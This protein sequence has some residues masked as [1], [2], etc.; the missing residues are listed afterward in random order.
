MLLPKQSRLRAKVRTGNSHEC[1]Q[2]AKK[3]GEHG[4]YRAVVDLLTATQSEDRYVAVNTA[5]A[6]RAICR[7]EKGPKA[8]QRILPELTLALAKCN[9]YVSDSLR[10]TLDEIDSNWAQAD[11][12][13]EAVPAL[14]EMLGSDEPGSRARAAEL[15]GLLRDTRSGA[16]LVAALRNTNPY[17]RATVAA[18]LGELGD[19][20]AGAALVAALKDGDTGMRSAGA[21]ALGK[22]GDPRAGA[23]LVAALKDRNAGV[24]SAAASALGELGDPRATAPLVAALE[25]K[26]ASVRGAAA[27]ALGRLGDLRAIEALV[28]RLAD[29]GCGDAA[30]AALQQMDSNWAQSRDARR[31][32][33]VLAAALVDTYSSVRDRALDALQQIDP[34]WARSDAAREALP[35]IISA[36]GDA[37]SGEA[38]TEALAMLGDRRA[39]GPLVLALSDYVAKEAALKALKRIDSHWETSDEAKSTIPDLVGL[40]GRPSA[41]TRALEVLD[42]L[43]A[44]WMES[45]AAKS[46]VPRLTGILLDEGCKPRRKMQVLKALAG[47]DP[48]WTR[49]CRSED[50]LTSLVPILQDKDD[51]TRSD[52]SEVAKALGALACPRAIAD[53]AVALAHGPYY[54]YDR[55][56]IGGALQ[57]IRPDWAQSEEARDALPRLVKA[58]MDRVDSTKKFAVEALEQIYPDWV[59]SKIA[60]STFPELARMEEKASPDARQAAADVL[61]TIVPNRG[62]SERVDTF[63]MNADA[64]RQGNRTE[65]LDLTSTP[66]SRSSLAVHEYLCREHY[67]KTIGRHLKWPPLDPTFLAGFESMENKARDQGVVMLTTSERFARIE[68]FKQLSGLGLIHWEDGG[69]S[70]PRLTDVGRRTKIR[71]VR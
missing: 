42:E 4:D 28:L 52:K 23:P 32:V 58:L 18:A 31:G 27:T 24:R 60:R 22:L 63:L 46:A 48:D 16:A 59:A 57:Q 55:E 14:V 35:E 9:T 69:H 43:D 67:S 13:K 45:E 38:A 37:F 70:T 54:G 61:R 50:V 20:R 33:S 2:A 41:P 40:I 64:E 44:T 53:L 19:P 30:L 66:L 10:S 17:V 25:S 12:A 56:V 3:L 36:L 7:R 1:V 6:T 11:A 49:S 29:A 26:E 62:I 34:N 51:A 71:L 21:S 8:L 39:I 68:V 65:V 15:L 5:N 47:I